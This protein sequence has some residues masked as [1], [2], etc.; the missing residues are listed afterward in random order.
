MVP[1]EAPD[2]SVRV[3][4]VAKTQRLHSNDL[5]ER[6]LLYLKVRCFDTFSC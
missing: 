5:T 2:R 1:I 3:L 4:V 6:T